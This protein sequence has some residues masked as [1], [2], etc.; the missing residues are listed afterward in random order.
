M[1]LLEIIRASKSFGRKT[2]L[3]DVSFT[4][5]PGSIL[6]V[7]GRNG[8]GKSTLLKLIFGTLRGGNIKLRINGED[9][10][11][12]EVIKNKLIGY[13]PQTPFLPRH[14]RVRDI[15]PIYHSGQKQQDAIF[16]DPEVAKIASRKVSELSHGERKYFEVVLLGHLDH[17]I[18][19]LDE[20]FTM[21]EPLQ[22]AAVSEFLQKLKST[23]GIII[24]DH[25]YND[26]LAISDK[27]LVLKDGIVHKVE[28][29]DDL[30]NYEYLRKQI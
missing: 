9:V 29:E 21:L 27:T 2:I 19:L 24:T 18:L 7:F 28:S 8:S 23:K 16:Y 17:P 15:I 11:N 20:P 26:V 12:S 3:E 30:R 5:E 1:A 14:L 25:Y 4:L 13:L 10:S 6:G 22:I